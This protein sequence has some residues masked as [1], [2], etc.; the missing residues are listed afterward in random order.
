MAEKVL[1]VAMAQNGVI[2]KDNGLPW[3]LSGDLK[4]FKATTSGYPIIM[5]RNTWE[6]LGRALPNRRNMVIS[7]QADYVAEG[8]EIFPSLE[9]AFEACESEEK[10]FCIGGALLYKAMLHIADRLVVTRVLAEVEGDTV[11]DE[12]NF[13]EWKLVA[14]ESHEAD[15]KNEYPFVIQEW[16]R[17]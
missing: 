10:A 6:S 15:E 7:R 8:A 11:F 14:E 4:H 1:I 16:V 5:G 2:G 12:I 13:D 3:R 9:E 17:G